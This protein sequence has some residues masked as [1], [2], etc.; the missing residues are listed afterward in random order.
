MR[1]RNFAS[2][3]LLGIFPFPL[4]GFVA[5]QPTDFGLWLSGRQYLPT[6]C[7]IVVIFCILLPGKKKESVFFL[8]SKWHNKEWGYRLLLLEP[9]LGQEMLLKQVMGCS[10]MVEQ[11]SFQDRKREWQGSWEPVDP[12]TCYPIWKMFSPGVSPLTS[13][14]SFF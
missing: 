10:A 1:E 14:D 6:W 4:W 12:S 2:T 11:S 8:G 13:L 7:F 5:V 3:S 9:A